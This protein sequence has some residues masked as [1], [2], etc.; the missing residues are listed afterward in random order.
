MF[1]F[2]S[3]LDLLVRFAKASYGSFQQDLG[4]VTQDG[5]L[6]L[7][8]MICLLLERME[9]SKGFLTFEKRTNRPHTSKIT[10]LPSKLLVQ[11]I[12]EAKS[13]AFEG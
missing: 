1:T 13:Q 10:L 12:Q 3:F 11:Q 2:P 6:I 5:N 7:A 4:I 8:E 9:L